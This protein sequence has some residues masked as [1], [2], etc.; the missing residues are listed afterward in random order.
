MPGNWY[1]VP[2]KG[3]EREKKMDLSNF[4]VAEMEVEEMV[5]VDGGYVYINI[6]QYGMPSV[7]D[8]TNVQ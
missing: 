4:D 8:S 6:N 2:S 3:K 1:R 5:E 7:V